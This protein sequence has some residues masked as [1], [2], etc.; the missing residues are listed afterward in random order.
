MAEVGINE[1]D[2][3]FIELFRIALSEETNELRHRAIKNVKHD[4]VN[5]RIELLMKEK[6][7]KWA[8]DATNR[9]FIEWVAATSIQRNDAAYEFSETG[10]RYEAKN[11]R[12]LNIAEHIGNVIFLSIRDGK[13]EGVQVNGGILERRDD[14]RARGYLD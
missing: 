8:S 6:G 11:E 13:F 10:K 9:N 2:L 7:P 3:Q 12:K 5:G 4:V 14:L 1:F